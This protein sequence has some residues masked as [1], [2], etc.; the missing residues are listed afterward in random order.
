MESLNN[1]KKLS[2]YE[3]ESMLPE[4]LFGGLDDTDRKN[5]ESSLVNFP[6]IQNEIKDVNA[7]FS[8]LD[9]MELNS[10][11]PNRTRNMS[12]KVQERLNRR[13]T[14][15]KNKAAFIKLAFPTLALMAMAYFLV[16]KTDYKNFSSTKTISSVTPKV[17]DKIENVIK[18]SDM[19]ALASDSGSETAI[20][21][22]V[23]HN[24]TVPVILDKSD[25]EAINDEQIDY[26]N[27]FVMANFIPSSGEVRAY[28]SGTD[29]NQ[30]NIYDD[31]DNLDESQ[32]QQLMKE[33]K[34]EKFSS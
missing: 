33:L 10:D 12:V 20:K 3:M 5:F 22:A 9:K 26:L 25:F 16:F 6:E 17:S 19:L 29:Y 24:S 32:F 30:I 21:T 27:Q 13:R 4:Y 11:I 1:I 2:K 23:Q 34:N 8:K 18:Q 14:Y 15:G 31:L 28:F 7:V